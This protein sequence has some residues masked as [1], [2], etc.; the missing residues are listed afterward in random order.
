ML[1]LTQKRTNAAHNGSLSSQDKLILGHNAGKTG[2]NGNCRH[3]WK[4]KL[5]TTDDS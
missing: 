4:S 3:H 1:D 5:L 2:M